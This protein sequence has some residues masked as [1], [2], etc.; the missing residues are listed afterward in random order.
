M[1]GNCCV[2]P[3][4]TSIDGI[5]V[6]N[7]RCCCICPSSITIIPVGSS[8]E[9]SIAP[10]SSCTPPRFCGPPSKPGKVSWRSP[11]SRKLEKSSSG[12]ETMGDHVEVE[13]WFISLDGL[14]TPFAHVAQCNGRPLGVWLW[15]NSRSIVICLYHLHPRFR[16]SALS[17]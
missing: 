6:G 17:L 14:F 13:S 12:P 7:S 10:A 15:Q 5:D 16:D 9:V 1:S 3:W 4:K 8:V 11:N 2:E